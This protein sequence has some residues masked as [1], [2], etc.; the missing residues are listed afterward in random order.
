[1]D[2]VWA[3]TEPLL[4]SLRRIVKDVRLAESWDGF[5]RGY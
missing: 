4:P 2:A 1:M 5:F 3:A